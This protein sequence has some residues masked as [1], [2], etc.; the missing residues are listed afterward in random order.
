MD[1]PD[2][3]LNE[4]DE[5]LSRDIVPQAKPSR[6]QSVARRL[7]LQALYEIDSV[8]HPP[9]EVLSRFI[10]ADGQSVSSAFSE[11]ILDDERALPVNLPDYVEAAG[12][13]DHPE[14]TALV[15]FRQLVLGVTDFIPQID[16]VLHAVAP[17]FPLHQM[18]V[19][20]RNTLR[21]ALY[22]IGILADEVPISVVIDEAVELAKAFGSDSS[23]RFVNGVLG[24]ISEN[25]D[26]VQKI[27]NTHPSRSPQK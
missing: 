13:N 9:E 12:T 6:L 3:E 26:V 14:Q 20:D 11:Y 22:E 16:K 7:A 27:F 17:D 1:Y 2:F 10:S 25:L 24:T 15:Y 23:S 21:I 8:K 19:V 18:A 5:I 4:G